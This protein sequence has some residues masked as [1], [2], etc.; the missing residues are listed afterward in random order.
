MVEGIEDMQILYGVDT[1]PTDDATGNV[2]P[3]RYYKA[4]DAFD[5][6]R[7]VSVRIGILSR[8]ASSADADVDRNTYDVNGRSVTVCP[9]SACTDRYQRRVFLATV[10]LR[11]FRAPE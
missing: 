8:T 5:W 6:S 1:D 2:M 11:N 7:V 10:Q 9:T 3:N 4:S